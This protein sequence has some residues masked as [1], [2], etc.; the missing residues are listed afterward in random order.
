MITI[1]HGNDT[2]SSRNYLFELKK[3]FPSVSFDKESFN[4]V[5]LLQILKGSTF[6][7][8]GKN[9]FI[10]NFLSSKKT[11]PDF[12]EFINLINKSDAKFNII[13]WENSELSKPTLFLFKDA[14]TKLFKIPQDLFSFLDNIKP[15]EKNNLVAFHNVLETADAEM[16]FF[17]MLRQFRLLLAL[18]SGSDSID[19]TKRL[20]PWQKEKL[21]RQAQ[22]FS[23][24][25]LKEIYNKLFEID[26]K[27][28]TGEITNLTN[29]IDILLLEI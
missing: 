18:S 10:E 25:K 23:F 3:S 13:F 15:N 4:Y 24:G 17:M 19:E 16:I 11:N 14:K 12:K 2:V 1:I 5:S 20:A 21:K 22:F 6:F 8:E 9:I 29:S 28:K 27:T 7:D 26:L